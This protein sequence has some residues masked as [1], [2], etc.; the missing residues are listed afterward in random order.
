[1][2]EKLRTNDSKGIGRRQSRVGRKT[3]KRLGHE[4]TVMLK[5]TFQS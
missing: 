5:T 2:S 1:M 3:T 4:R